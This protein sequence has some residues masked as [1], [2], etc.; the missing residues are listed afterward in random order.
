MTNDIRLQN[1][2]H[3]LD[4]EL[5]LG[6]Y[7][8]AP[9]SADASF[10]RYFRISQ[11]QMS[12]VA[13]DAP[14][15]KEDCEP[16]IKIASLIEAVN[17]HAP[18]IYH[19]N[20]DEGYLLLSDL[21]S[22]AYLDALNND[23]ADHLY[24]DAIHALIKLQTID[25]KLKKYD[26]ELLHQ[27]MNLFNDWY[28]STH[29]NIKLDTTQLE[30]ISQC[31]TLLSANAIQ[32]IQTFVHRDYHCRNLMLTTENNPGVIDFQDAVHGPIT[33]D[34]VSLLKD[35]YI[36]WPRQKVE[37]WIELFMQSS[38][39]CTELEVEQFIKWFDLM[40]MQ[41]HLKAAG[42]FARLNHRDNKPN[43]L[44]DIPRTLAYIFD[45]CER[46]DELH[47]FGSL[48]NDLHIQADAGTLKLIK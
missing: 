19:R 29:L 2:Q 25:D 48:L 10:R 27:E 4:N 17:V 42:I 39:L 11:N 14:P 3:W 7:N 16:F 31:Y 5:K 44:N 35:C 23:S 6:S 15:D 22:Q 40:G 13:M 38:P 41:R 37:H 12:W 8:I 36:A 20:K 30:T 1:L 26:H 46:Y 21:G 34:L 9:A 32:Q 47:A 33:Y 43:Y 45:V 24:N 18:H 28:L